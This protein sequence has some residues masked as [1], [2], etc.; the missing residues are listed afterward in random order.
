MNPTKGIRAE[1]ELGSLSTD[2]TRKSNVEGEGLEPHFEETN[3]LDA[4]SGRKSEMIHLS[5]DDDD[6][7]VKYE[8]VP[9]LRTTPEVCSF[10][11]HSVQH[12]VIMVFRE[13]FHVGCSLL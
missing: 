1:V 13:W 7:S 4:Y 3:L 8:N 6:R 5:D 9:L 10:L 11:Q 12:G 2:T